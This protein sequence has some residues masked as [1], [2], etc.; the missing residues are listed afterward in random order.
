MIP[1]NQYTRL[2]NYTQIHANNNRKLS[3]HT[4]PEI[5]STTTTMN[6][7]HDNALRLPCANS[8]FKHRLLKFYTQTELHKAKIY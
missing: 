5:L 1:T 2:L 7:N 4:L 8:N 6:N 3:P